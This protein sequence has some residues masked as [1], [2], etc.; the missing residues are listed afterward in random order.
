M[1]TTEITKGTKVQVN[2]SRTAYT[3]TR[4]SEMGYDLRGP[5]G[6]QRH[7]VRNINSGKLVMVW[8]SGMSAREQLVE[9]LTV[10]A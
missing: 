2:G 6:G 8:V 5:R 1:T 10:A 9:S 4:V 7:I 3:V